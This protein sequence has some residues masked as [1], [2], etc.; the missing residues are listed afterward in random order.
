[1]MDYKSCVSWQQNMQQHSSAD[2]KPLGIHHQINQTVLADTVCH[3]TSSA[4]L[5]PDRLSGSNKQTSCLHAEEKA[6]QGSSSNW[7][8]TLKLLSHQKKS[9][10]E[11]ENFIST[12]I[13][14]SYY[15]Y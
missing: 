8:N 4:D 3:L 11:S 9:V 2:L 13:S 14:L 15:A 5:F 10:H 1:M 6:C 12:A 7:E